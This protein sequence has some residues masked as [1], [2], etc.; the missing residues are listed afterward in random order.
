MNAGAEDPNCG[1]GS[2]PFIDWTAVMSICDYSSQKR[3]GRLDYMRK[4][5][6]PFTPLYRLQ[7]ARDWFAR[8]DA[9]QQLR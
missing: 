5:N 6:W 1:I 2:L 8:R 7:L 9:L 3:L 4:S